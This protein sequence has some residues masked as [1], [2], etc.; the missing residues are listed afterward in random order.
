MDFI[1]VGLNY[2]LDVL[3]ES[4]HVEVVDPRITI[5]LHAIAYDRE[6]TLGSRGID[7]KRNKTVKVRC[8]RHN[9]PI[10]LR[11]RPDFLPINVS[12][13]LLFFEVDILLLFAPELINAGI[14]N[15]GH[16]LSNPNGSSMSATNA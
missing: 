15:L 6:D 4:L 8:F 16:Q 3:C 10:V 2:S 1:I 13:V 9:Q 7:G 11:I 12:D 14:M 5:R